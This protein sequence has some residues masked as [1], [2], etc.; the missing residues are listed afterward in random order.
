MTQPE[1]LANSNH[2]EPKCVHS[3]TNVLVL[4]VYGNPSSTFVNIV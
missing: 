1:T 2:L 3:S 4:A